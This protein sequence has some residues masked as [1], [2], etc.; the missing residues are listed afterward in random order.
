MHKKQ[1]M[2]VSVNTSDATKQTMPNIPT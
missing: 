2:H 1:K